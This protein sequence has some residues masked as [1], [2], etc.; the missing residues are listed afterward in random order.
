M[1]TIHAC[2]LPLLGSMAWLLPSE[3][4]TSSSREQSWA[5]ACGWTALMHLEGHSTVSCKDPSWSYKCN[6]PGVCYMA[7]QDA[8]SKFQALGGGYLPKIHNGDFLKIY[9]SQLS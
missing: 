5:P 1:T 2:V 4:P 9:T 6:S 3:E 7:L 8:H